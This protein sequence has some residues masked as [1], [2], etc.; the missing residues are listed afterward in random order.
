MESLLSHDEGQIYILLD[1]GT[2]STSSLRHIIM[3]EC[4]TSFMSASGP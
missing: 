3:T 2:I 1:D 4:K